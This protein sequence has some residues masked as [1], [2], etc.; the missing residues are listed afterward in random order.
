MFVRGG[1][2]LDV[3][4]GVADSVEELLDVG[5]T[6]VLVDRRQVTFL[7]SAGVH[8]LVSAHR[9]AERRGSALALTRGP[10]NVRRV[11]ELAASNGW[12][13]FDDGGSS[14]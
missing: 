9:S 10:R 2:D 3:A 13:A 12:L 1:I 14:V 7:D 5:F 6:R 11:F 8:A 4:R